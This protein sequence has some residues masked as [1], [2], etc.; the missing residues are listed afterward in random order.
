MLNPLMLQNEAGAI[1]RDNKTKKNVLRE[2]RKGS[3]RAE[4]RELRAY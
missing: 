2:R 3:E 4:S 1:Q